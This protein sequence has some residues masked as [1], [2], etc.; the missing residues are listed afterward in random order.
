MQD[1]LCETS[2]D[3]TISDVSYKEISIAKD[4]L[5]EE[6]EEEEGKEHRG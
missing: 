2:A 5:E 4:R 6:E 1:I 3:M